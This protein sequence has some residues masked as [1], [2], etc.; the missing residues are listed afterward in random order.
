MMT[1]T[2]TMLALAAA[3]GMAYAAEPSPILTQNPGFIDLDADGA[4]GDGWG[5]FGAAQVDFDFFGDGNPGHGV[6]YGDNAGNSGGVFEAGIPASA[7]TTYEMTV[8]IQWEPEWDARTFYALEFYAADDTTK[9]DEV[10]VEI[11]DAPLFAGLGYRRFD[12]QATA[13]AGTAFVRPV[14]S[15]SEAQSSGAS[16]AATVDN[17]LVREADDVLNLN[18]SFGDISGEGTTGD[19]WGQ[20]GAANV[21]LDFFNNGNPGQGTLFADNEGNFGGVFQTGIPATN[22]ESYTFTVDIAFEEN[23]DARTF[24]GLEFFG[25]D[26]GFLLGETALEITE[27]PGTGYVTYQIEA[28]APADFT[29][30]VR[31]IVRFFDAVGSG[32]GKAAVVDNAV[33]QLTSTVG[34]E[35]PADLAEPFGTLNFFDLLAY[36]SAFN[37]GDP[38]ADIAAPSGNLN[39]FDLLEYISRF[40]TGCP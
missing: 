13:P 4:P 5:T 24:F 15:F 39:F 40:N 11:F 12:L 14:I 3:S 22:G 10:V 1:R 37:A 16:R 2:T 36:I 25:A 21:F 17:V 38:S 30:F 19:Q 27:Q 8:K 9:L 7:G 20:F 29:A 32:G 28:V 26:D 33:V 31:P 35:C 34:T 6:L 23:W 18:P